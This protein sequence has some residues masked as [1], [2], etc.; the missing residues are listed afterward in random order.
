[1][2]TSWTPDETGMS[3]DEWDED[4]EDDWD[5]AEEDAQDLIEQALQ[6]CGQTGLPGHCAHA[7]TEHCSYRCPFYRALLG[8]R[9]GDT[10]GDV[11]D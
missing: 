10:H 1:M 5:D 4:N 7:G 6:D 9:E 2:S 11:T 3:D 8:Q